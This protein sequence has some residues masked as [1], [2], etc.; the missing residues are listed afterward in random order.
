MKQPMAAIKQ[1]YFRSC[2]GM[3]SSRVCS[4][5]NSNPWTRIKWSMASSK[6]NERILR[7]IKNGTASPSFVSPS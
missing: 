6:K 5:E 4:R 3:L 7:T 2:G 1:R